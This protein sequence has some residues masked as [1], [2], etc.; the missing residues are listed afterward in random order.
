MSLALGLY[1]LISSPSFSRVHGIL[2][3]LPLRAVQVQGGSWGELLSNS[4]ASHPG[5][6]YNISVKEV[7]SQMVAPCCRVTQLVGSR[8]D[9]NPAQSAPEPMVSLCSS[10]P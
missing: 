5:P 6:V 9:L 3:S 1:H 7:M 10:L 8:G 4:C 2:G